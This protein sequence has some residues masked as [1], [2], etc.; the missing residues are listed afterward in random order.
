M[1]DRSETSEPS[2]GVTSSSTR[3]VPV[4][5]NSVDP[6]GAQ[7]PLHLNVPVAAQLRS[8][9]ATHT[10]AAVAAALAPTSISK[11]PRPLKY[12]YAAD[13]VATGASQSMKNIKFAD[14][15]V[16]LAQRGQ[17]RISALLARVSTKTYP[18]QHFVV[19]CLEL[20]DFE[21]IENEKVR[22]DIALLRQ[23][24]RDTDKVELDNIAHSIVT[25]CQL[26]L[27]LMVPKNTTRKLEPTIT[28][29]GK[30]VKD[31]KKRIRAAQKSKLKLSEI[32]IISL[33]KLERL[34]KA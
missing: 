8:A 22:N 19:S 25:A 14:V 5:T 4:P 32:K 24:K 1:D 16:Q 13:Q 21:G 33:E 11:P 7:A 10:A 30:R 31:Y 26:Q 3:S 17:F 18:E 15:L 34:E 12:G 20:A 27:I 28:G 29:M 23:A 2:A 6:I 9:T